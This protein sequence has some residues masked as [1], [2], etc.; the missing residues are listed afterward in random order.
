MTALL[1]QPMSREEAI[2]EYEKLQIE[3]I[4][5]LEKIKQYKETH[6]GEY[7]KLLPHQQQLWD[8][9]YAGKTI[10]VLQGA[11][12]IGKEQPIYSKV[13]TPK[14]VKEIGSLLVGDE[15]IGEDGLPHKVIGVYPQGIKPA[16]RVT[17]ND[18][19]YTDCGLEHL[20]KIRT[21]SS[22]YHK[23]TRQGNPSPS[24]NQ[25]KILSLKEIIENWGYTPR[26]DN[27]VSIPMCEPVQFEMKEDLKIYPYLLGVLI[28]DGGLNHQII[29][30]SADNEI[31][32]KVQGLLPI[33][34]K[35]NYIGN[36]GYRIVGY[37]ETN[38][39]HSKNEILNE[40]RNLKLNVK[41][42]NKFIPE[43][44]KYTSAENRIELLRGLMD[45]DGSIH[46]LRTIEYSS[47]SKQ[48]AM[49]VVWLVQ[50]LGGQAKITE[51]NFK[52][53]DENKICYRVMIKIENINPF[54][55]ERKAKR[56]YKISRRKERILYNIQYIGH[57]PSVCIGVD[58][59]EHTY[60]TDNFIVTHN[61][62]CL[63]DF[64]NANCLGYL[65]RDK[66]KKTR[67]SPPI[68][69][70][71]IC[72]DWERHAKEVIIP[73][74]YQYFTLDQMVKLGD[75]YGKKNQIGVESFFQYKNGSTVELMTSNLQPK[76]Y[77]GWTGHIIAADEPFDKFIYDASVRGLSETDGV[78]L[79]TLTSV[80]S[81]YDWILNDVIE[82]TNED[83]QKNIGCVRGVHAYA[84][85]FIPKTNFDKV[86][87]NWD[88]K[89]K[90]ARFGGEW[91]SGQ[92]KVWPEFNYDT[93]VCDE[94]KIPTD[95]PVVA[96]IDYHACIEQAVG[97]YAFD[98]P[99]YKYVIDEIW[100]KLI[101]A[102]EEIAD[103]IIRRKI[104]N[105]WRLES[106]YIDPFSVGAHKMVQNRGVN[107]QDAFSVIEARLS[108]HDIV[109][110]IA[111]K[112]KKSGIENVRGW[113]K[114]V[115]GL[116]TLRIFKKCK[117]HIYEMKKWEL[118]DNGKPADKDDHMCEN[119]YRVSL[120]GTEWTDLKEINK[121]YKI[122]LAACA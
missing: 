103:E 60:L 78:F 15:V 86:A 34:H 36:Y 112:D 66:T 115:N 121:P 19:S 69:V 81:S 77:E 73:K 30:T 89:T 67:W 82:S 65:P 28:G 57:F 99:G 48:L 8:Y 2:R 122:H 110:Y 106:A 10:L 11:N 39:K 33:K 46:G 4:Q 42:Q 64:V 22:K 40:I 5:G 75:A 47:M 31:I 49:D 3:H 88:E 23:N 12:Q 111:D 72:A 85:T 83:M 108:R 38:D 117:R 18:N 102:P 59:K 55:L 80:D 44:Y 97:F 79:F 87:L 101:P 41:S 70:R 92:G 45:T 94:F 32:N 109:L 27:R 95:F 16:Y 54:S 120:T 98:K 107:L 84:N 93:L 21:P 53:N 50:S 6:G 71:I 20:W 61:T 90:K 114:G 91:Y 58:S 13:Y 43:K 24:Y 52:Y 62:I 14:G 25:W 29:I 100:E 74:L 37:R 116:P 63:A 76:A 119:I 68:K 118:D 35:I 9:Y 26:E 51:K 1:E 113:L 104:A 17:F 96:M 56:F 7:L 105:G